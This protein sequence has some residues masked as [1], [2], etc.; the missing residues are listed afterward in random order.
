MVAAPSSPRRSP[1]SPA[2]TSRRRIRFAL[3]RI[4]AITSD[5]VHV[6]SAERR[7]RDQERTEG[8][9]GGESATFP[10]TASLFWREIQRQAPQNPQRMT[11]PMLTWNPGWNQTTHLDSGGAGEANILASAQPRPFS[12]WPSEV[13]LLIWTTLSN[14]LRLGPHTL[15][16]SRT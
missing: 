12:A 4:A 14:I 8:R 11:T 10:Q 16:S 13:S 15:P 1:A 5:L 2:N 7:S 6:W 9:E 3:S